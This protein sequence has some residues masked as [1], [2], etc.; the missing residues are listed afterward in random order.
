MSKVE[1]AVSSFNQGYNCSQAL[2]EAYSEEMGVEREIALRVSSAFGG[3]MGCTAQTCGAATGA[4]MVLGLK[5]GHTK[6][7]PQKDA[8]RAGKDLL[9]EF[10]RRN[11]STLCME[12]LKCDISTGEGMKEAQRQRLFS[13]VCPRLVR[14]AAEILEEML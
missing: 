10:K 7:S 1:K 9:E 8:Y 4:L 2:L 3:G 11:G 14:A 6:N 13:T 5:H 12:L